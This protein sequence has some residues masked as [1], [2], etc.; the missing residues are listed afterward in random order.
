MRVALTVTATRRVIAF[1]LGAL[2]AALVAAH[3]GHGNAISEDQAVMLATVQ[4]GRLVDDRKLESS[5]RLR[6]E[7]RAV[8]QRRHGDSMEYVVVFK[9][10]AASDPDRATLYVFLSEIGEYVA[11][12]FSGR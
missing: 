5:W 6:A 7:M 4:I 10:P 1:L 11:A 3:P 8:E 9:N 12:N 2:G